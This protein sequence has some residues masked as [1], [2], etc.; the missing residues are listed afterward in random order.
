MTEDLDKQVRDAIAALIT[1]EQPDARVY[2]WNAL[3]H[4]LSEWPGLFRTELGA[5]HGWIIKQSSQP[6]EWKHGR[7]DRVKVTYD[8]WGFYKFRTGR[9]GD[10]S[11]DEFA[12]IRAQVYNAIKGETRLGF[13]TEVEE[14]DLLQYT[15]VTTIDC[16]EETLHFAQGKL[17]VHLCC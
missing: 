4:N 15:R 1:G 12:V 11:D 8:V 13:E 14:H 2:G 7:R 3:S 5:T 6:A 9:A 16:G 10:N 17:T